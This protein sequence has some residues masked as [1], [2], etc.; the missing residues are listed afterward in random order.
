M[1]QGDCQYGSDRCASAPATNQPPQPSAGCPR[2]PTPSS[3]PTA[4][5]SLHLHSN[6]VIPRACPARTRVCPWH[7]DEWPAEL[8]LEQARGGDAATGGTCGWT[9]T[10]SSLAPGARARSCWPGPPAAAW[11]RQPSPSRFPHHSCPRPRPPPPAAPP[12]YGPRLLRPPPHSR[13]EPRGARRDG[14]RPSPPRRGSD[15]QGSDSCLPRVDDSSLA[16]PREACRVASG[17]VGRFFG[18]S[19]SG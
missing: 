1:S 6:R 10:A 8:H 3:R 5:Q 7:T 9:R 13:M 11:G 14:R 12:R 17:R 4:A 19:A 15:A 16:Q 18:I 2:P